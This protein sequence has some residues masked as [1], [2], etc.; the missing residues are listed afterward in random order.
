MVLYISVIVCFGLYFPLSIL[1]VTLKLFG[2]QEQAKL[3]D[4]K[5][6]TKNLLDNNLGQ[7]R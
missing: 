6:F 5:F 4:L 2:R 1:L 7:P 3:S